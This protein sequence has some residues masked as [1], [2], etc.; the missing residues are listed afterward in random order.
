MV[1]SDL[2]GGKLAFY[3]MLLLQVLIA[4]GMRSIFI[5]MCLVPEERMSAWALPEY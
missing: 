2:Q 1:F 4:N 3:D 5:G